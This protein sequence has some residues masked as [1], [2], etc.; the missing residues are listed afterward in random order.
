MMDQGGRGASRRYRMHSSRRRRPE[1]GRMCRH[2]A[3]T[4]FPANYRRSPQASDAQGVRG[5]D[6]AC[7]IPISNELP[8]AP[9]SIPPSPLISWH[10]REYGNK[11]GVIKR[12][13]IEKKVPT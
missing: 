9:A 13:E 6:R 7:A 8:S 5:E 11:G 10:R 12:R 4:N 2:I 1:G 3:R